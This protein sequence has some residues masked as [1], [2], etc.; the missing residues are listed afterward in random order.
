MET[1]L[2]QFINTSTKQQIVRYAPEI[3]WQKKWFSF[4]N[5]Q[6]LTFYP[7]CPLTGCERYGHK[8]CSLQIVP[9]TEGNPAAPAPDATV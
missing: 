8:T 4:Y 1:K 2:E 6:Y 7:L 5:L 3:R 9:E